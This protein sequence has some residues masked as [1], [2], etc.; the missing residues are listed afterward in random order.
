MRVKFK[1]QHPLFGKVA[2]PL[3]VGHQKRSPYY[4]W[5]QY[6]RRNAAYLE[7]CEAGG[8]G[9]LANLYADFGD[10]RDD[11]FKK[12]WI[13]ANRGAL[14]FGEK[15]LPDTLK[16]LTAPTEWDS[17]WTPNTVMV[18]AV[19]MEMGKRDLQRY[20]GQLLKKRHKG[21][22][23]RK[24]L[25]D[26]D[27]STAS[28]PLMRNVTVRALERQL[29]VYDAVIASKASPKRVTLAMIGQSL[30]L[31]PTAMPHRH[32]N[33]Y[34]AAEK[35]NVMGATVSRYFKEAERIIANTAKGQFPN[36]K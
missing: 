32:D 31:V 34:E 36:S 33:I 7:C 20:F 12:W 6:L 2:N 17:T 21:E 4:W 29:N 26:T 10:V 25:S 18:V 11:D 9:E 35:R 3:P 16:E 15:P 1:A 24:A 13:G 30:A 14:L 8:K 5:W 22:R 27:A 28:Y 23:G 19:P